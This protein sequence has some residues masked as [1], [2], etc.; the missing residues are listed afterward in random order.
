MLAE[1]VIGELEVS[2]DRDRCQFATLAKMFI[3]LAE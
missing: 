1:D 2:G 3:W